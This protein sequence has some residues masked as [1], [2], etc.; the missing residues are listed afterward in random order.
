LVVLSDRDYRALI[1][2]GEMVIDPPPQDHDFQP[3]SIEIRMGDEVWITNF[4]LPSFDRRLLERFG[5]RY[6]LKK[7]EDLTLYPGLVYYVK[8]QSRFRIPFPAKTEGRSSLGRLGVSAKAVHRSHKY[9][10]APYEGFLWFVVEAHAFPVKIYPGTAICHLVFWDPEKP[11]L[12]SSE[13]IVGEYGRA[14]G[15]YGGGGGLIELARVRR[16]NALQ[17]TLSGRE[18]KRGIDR[19]RPFDIQTGGDEEEYFNVIDITEEGVV[20]EAGKF[21]LGHASE[22]VEVGKEVIG[23]LQQ[24]DPESGILAHWEAGL[25]DPGFVGKPVLEMMHFGKANLLLFPG[26]EIGKLV[27]ERL[28]SPCERGYGDFRGKAGKGKY[29]AQDG[30]VTSRISME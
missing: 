11:D 17:L 12:M 25:F 23:F 3:S 5:K 16:G 26:Q 9:L 7:G 18:L 20:M 10:E 24:L 6:R 4:K 15:L 22:R 13:E 30:T 8:S 21:Y 2:S 19:G 1:E 29:Y 27:F 14:F 28:S